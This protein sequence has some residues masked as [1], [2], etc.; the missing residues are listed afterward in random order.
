MINLTDKE[1]ML[2]EDK[3]SQEE[4]QEHGEKSITI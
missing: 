2:L 3:K 1:R 4:E